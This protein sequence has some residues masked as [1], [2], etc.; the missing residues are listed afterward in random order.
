MCELQPEDKKK[1]IHTPE[2]LMQTEPHVRL[3]RQKQET[4]IASEQSEPA[5]KGSEASSG[6]RLIRGRK[7]AGIQLSW[8]QQPQ[9]PHPA[10]QGLKTKAGTPAVPLV[11]EQ[12]HPLVASDAPSRTLNRPSLTYDPWG[13]TSGLR[14]YM[15]FYQT[16]PRAPITHSPES[17][18]LFQQCLSFFLFIGLA[19]LSFKYVNPQNGICITLEYF[20]FCRSKNEETLTN[21]LQLFSTNCRGTRSV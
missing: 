14:M 16:K 7:I 15:F 12:R 18:E 21:F 20:T 17:T 4:R 10:C 8:P 2:Q 13:H 6:A 5:G 1:K 9:Q 11:E 3:L 19:F